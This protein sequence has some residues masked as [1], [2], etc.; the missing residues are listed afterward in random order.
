MITLVFDG[1]LKRPVAP[2]LQGV[3]GGSADAAAEFPAELHL[4]NFTRRTHP[5]KVT[6]VQLDHLIAV[7]KKYNLY[8]EVAR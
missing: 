4:E 1:H 3:Y 8:K 7:S 2:R 6:Q 5:V